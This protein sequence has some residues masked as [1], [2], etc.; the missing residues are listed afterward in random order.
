MLLISKVKGKLAEQTS[1]SHPVPALCLILV[2]RFSPFSLDFTV[3]HQSHLPF[4]AFGTPGDLDCRY[5]AMVSRCWFL[6]SCHNCYSVRRA[7]RQWYFITVT[8]KL[9]FPLSD[10]C[11]MTRLE[12]TFA[13]SSVKHNLQIWRVCYLWIHSESNQ[14]LE[15][16][17]NG[18]GLGLSIPPGSYTS[19]LSHYTPGSGGPTMS[20]GNQLLRSLEG[21]WEFIQLP[22]IH[23]RSD[24]EESCHP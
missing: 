23:S 8:N 7:T 3:P 19:Q 10:S 11:C 9:R 1:L 13:I 24:S 15:L 12:L 4:N 18:S 22:Q 17:W 20:N 2:P 5:M 21:T 16:V 6:N 14:D